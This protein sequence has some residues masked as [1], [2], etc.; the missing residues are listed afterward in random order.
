MTNT[1]TAFTTKHDSNHLTIL[2]GWHAEKQWIN[3]ETV[4]TALKFKE[5]PGALMPIFEVQCNGIDLGRFKHF[6]MHA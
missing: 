5:I 3:I 6:L 4:V 1:P 2:A